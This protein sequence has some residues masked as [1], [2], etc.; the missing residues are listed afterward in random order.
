MRCQP[1]PSR[2]LDEKATR[3][4]VQHRLI[5]AGGT[6]EEFSFF[7]IRSIHEETRGVPRLINKMCDLALVYAAAGT[8]P[9]VGI[10]VIRELVADGLFIKTRPPQEVYVLQN[11]IKQNMGKAAE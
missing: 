10:D 9:V 3:A 6:G 4:Y 11:P 1:S 2:P 7:A 8:R 5:H